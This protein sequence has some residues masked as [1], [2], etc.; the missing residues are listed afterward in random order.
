VWW[1]NGRW[2][3]RE[4]DLGEMKWR[5][6]AATACAA[7]FTLLVL[8]GYYHRVDDTVTDTDR[9]YIEKFLVS[10]RVESLPK[11][12]SYHDELRFI[13]QT[14]RA[15]QEA[16]DNGN[17]IPM[18]TAR[19]PKDVWM[20]PKGL[21]FDTSRVIE[22]ILRSRGFETRHVGIWQ[23]LNSRWAIKSLLTPGIPSHAV[24]E[25]G[26][27]RGWL[28]IDPVLPWIS[29]NEDNDPVSISRIKADVDTK[30]IAWKEK[31]EKYRWSI[32]KEPFT[33]LY[34]VYSW[35]GRFYP[36]YNAVPDISWPEFLYNL[37]YVRPSLF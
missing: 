14:Q 4:E 30:K 19:E 20:A 34:G 27:K 33:F 3:R 10:G 32:Y 29:L 12:P 8:I 28:V 9:E 5:Y 6:R 11:T 25:V 37:G 22:K 26:T 17:P 7:V 13:V 23:T 36:P 16:I 15:V 1:R 21:C 31:F 24:T 35:H 2:T 18:N